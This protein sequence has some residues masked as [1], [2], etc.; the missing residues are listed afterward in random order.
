MVSH[1]GGIWERRDAGGGPIAYHDFDIQLPGGEVVALEVT[2]HT[3]SAAVKARAAVRKKDWSFAC[4]RWNWVVNIAGHGHDVREIHRRIPALL[5]VLEEAGIET[6]H[7][8]EDPPPGPAQAALE[9]LRSLHARLVYR[10]TD[11]TDGAGRVI[12]GEASVAGAT[13][14][15]VVVQAAEHQGNMADNSGKLASAEADER[16]LFIWVESHP[17]VAAAMA[18]DVLPGQ[19]PTLPE[20]I[21]VVW[22]AT[23]TSPSQVW[24]H[25]RGEG[26]QDLGYS[27]LD[28]T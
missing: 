16:H 28:A 11:A 4:L 6:A 27:Y 13:S 26:W 19:A 12:L 24:R 23:A 8:R 5:A 20:H 2:R 7:L 10:H 18:S 14:P 17:H 21:D 9:G 3:L 15:Q 1:L 22:L 25:V